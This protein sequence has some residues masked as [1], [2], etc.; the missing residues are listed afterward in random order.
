MAFR[1]RNVFGLS[2]DGALVYANELS[3]CY[4][5]REDLGIVLKSFDL[6]CLIDETNGLQ[7]VTSPKFMPKSTGKL[8]LKF[9]RHSSRRLSF[10]DLYVEFKKAFSN[11][12]RSQLV[13][14]GLHCII[15][16]C[17]RNCHV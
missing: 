11:N 10:I 9:C 4:H 5:G 13:I 3:L 2:R 16:N 17:S 15:N 8:L 7:W 14:Y 1:A 12:H 6:F